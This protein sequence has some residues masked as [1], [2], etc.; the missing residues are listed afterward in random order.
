MSAAQ[1]CI[2]NVRLNGYNEELN[3]D[4]LG[5]HPDASDTTLR[6]VLARHYGCDRALLYD[7]IIVRE[8]HAIS[9]H[10]PHY[11]EYGRG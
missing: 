8:P 3:L 11:N 7:Y 10:P 4:D 1:T 9:V 2:L 5:L 6:T